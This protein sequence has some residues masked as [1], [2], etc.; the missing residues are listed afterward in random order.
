MKY[1]K[2]TPETETELC[3]LHKEGLSY[4]QIADKLGCSL[5]GAKK[6]GSKY[7]KAGL[8][9]KR[10]Q[11]PVPV[12]ELFEALRRYKT[13]DAAPSPIV[14]KVVQHFGSWE[15]GLLAAQLPLNIGGV[16][17]INK[18]TIL[19]L[20]K[21]DGFYKIGITQQTLKQRFAGAPPFLVIDT[22]ISDLSEIVELEK[23]ILS[24]VTQYIPTNPWFERK[25]K[26]ECF[27]TEQE[28][29]EISDLL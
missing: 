5:D 10:T 9:D 3:N 13:R 14:W 21:F 27:I 24:N 12:E 6:I 16:M 1:F 7:I 25:G 23:Q 26:T 18:P 17:D 2:W 22:Y 19:Y 8:L 29:K 11:T 20:L 28:L 15:K 4:A